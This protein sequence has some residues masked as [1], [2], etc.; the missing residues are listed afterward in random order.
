MLVCV[1]LKLMLLVVFVVLMI[2]RVLFVLI[3]WMG[4]VILVEVLLCG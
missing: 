4:V 3:C 1:V 2:V